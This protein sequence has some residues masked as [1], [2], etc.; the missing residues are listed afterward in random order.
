MARLLV[1]AL[2]TACTG[3]SVPDTPRSGAPADPP[4]EPPP[5]ARPAPEAAPEAPP[6]PPFTP[7]TIQLRATFAVDDVTDTLRPFTLQGRPL[8]VALDLFVSDGSPEPTTCALRLTPTSPAPPVTRPPGAA[9]EAVHA[10]L[11]LL[12]GAFDVSDREEPELG[13]AGCIALAEQ[14]PFSPSPW[15]ADPAAA[16]A[17]ST[18]G[19]YVGPLPADVAARLD[20][21][22]PYARGEA[23]GAL[24]V[25]TTL[26]EAL[27]PT[28]SAR[29]LDGDRVVMVGDKAVPIEPAAVRADDGLLVTGA[30]L[31]TSDEVVFPAAALLSVE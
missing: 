17:A 6:G 19:V 9:N 18:W 11:T 10:G 25:T 20:P 13:V 23:T 7:T 29:R 3:A 5:E 28:G 30:Y 2:L 1:L 24:L 8:P 4:L 22:H 21:G 27:L 14:R 26:G 16:V 31:V 12:P 15:G